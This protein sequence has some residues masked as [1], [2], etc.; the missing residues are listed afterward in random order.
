[1]FFFW[2]ND[3]V[4]GRA[5]RQAV[6][7]R[8]KDCHTSVYHCIS[9]VVGG[10][11]LLDEQAREV[12]RKMLWKVAGFS[13][14]EI[15]AYCLMSN[16]I[17]LLVRVP[18]DPGEALSRAELLRR[19]ALIYGEGYAGVFPDP[20]YLAVIL[21]EDSPEAGRWEG[22]LR[23][24]M[25]DVSA[26]MKTLK[27]RF[28]WWY[29][30]T[31]G[32]FG[33]LWAERFK[34]V[35]LED[36]PRTLTVVA[37]YLDLNPVRAGLVKDPADYRWSSYGEAMGGEAAARAGLASVVGLSQW[38]LEGLA[39][40]RR[41]LYGKGGQGRVGEQGAIDPERVQAVL[42]AGGQVAL[43]E[44]LRCRVRYLSDGAILG[45]EEFV[46]A[47]GGKLGRRSQ[48]KDGKKAL[49]KLPV[50]G[51]AAPRA[52]RKLQVRAIG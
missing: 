29:N 4:K 44:L 2:Q 48:A 19:Y 22:R 21:A 47:M 6:G 40:Y 1:M 46:R 15:L 16:H 38:T 45:S 11:R 18:E 36:D 30:R 5:G 52:W 9:R 28:S 7:M 23:A 10:E 17:H 32:R 35:L 43:A 14:V 50:E 20:D 34:S 13:G 49:G 42:A 27:Q 39:D 33:T 25:H 12:F 37:A 31:H 41:V 24:R 8:I 3:L 26:F 51:G